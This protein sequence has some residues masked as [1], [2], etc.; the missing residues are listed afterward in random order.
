MRASELRGAA[1]AGAMALAL[2][3]LAPVTA[4]RGVFVD[5]LVMIGAIGG[6]GMLARRVLRSELVAGAVQAAVGVLALCG[7]ALAAR[8]SG[9]ELPRVLAAG[10][11][12]TVTSTAPMGPNPGVRLIAAAAIGVLA[13]L[14]DQL[15]VTYRHA[16]WTL[17][18]LGVPYLLAALALP[19]EASFG[20]LLSLAGGYLLVLLADTAGRV[21]RAAMSTRPGL[22]LL[23]GGLACLLAGASIAVVAGLVTP[24]L[25]PGR[26]APF[27]GQGPIQ[28]GDPSLDLRR[29]L[30]QPADQQ[31]LTYTT[32]TGNGVRL[33]LT[34]LPVFDASGFRLTTRELHTGGVL[35]APPGAPSGLPR[36]QIN[37]SV[38]AFN[39]EWLPL[40]YAP[41]S[42][43]ASG[44]WRHDPLSMSVLATGDR[45]TSATNGL[46]YQATVVDVDP[47]AEQVAAAHAGTPPDA[48]A[49][50]ALPD[51]LPPRI[52]ALAHEI[53]RRGTTDGRRAVLIQDW[54][55]SSA[56]SYSLE[57]APGSGYDALTR[58]LFEDRIGYC[59]QFAT[60]MAV[61]AR[62]VGIPARVAVGFLPGNRDG[63][64]WDVTIHN[65]HA[66]PELYLDGLGWVAFEPTPA[67]AEPPGYAGGNPRAE[68]S[69]SPTP[70]PSATDDEPSL[71]PE[72]P[73]PVPD[74][75]PGQSTNTDWPS[76]PAGAVGLVLLGAA[77]SVLRHR[78]RAHRLAAQPARAAVT[79]AWDEVR[80][81]AWDAGREWPRGSARQIAAT[82]AADLPAEAG[83]ALVRVGMLVERARYADDLGE[84][85]DVATDVR[86][87][88]A[89]LAAGSDG[90]SRWGRALLPRSLWRRLRWRG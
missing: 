46:R 57:P 71:G 23:A 43:T 38:G 28:M 79:G 76:W 78:R 1:V 3:A 10:L 2:P 58:F 26:G 14:A 63:D 73:Q 34:A 61:L 84:V 15:A 30:Q 70:T 4:D 49:T 85:S 81:S 68:P 75:G 39:S 17:L 45:R 50:A 7:L 60:S 48:D 56:F 12:W 62:A 24:G 13:F 90:L 11:E 32:S 65:M 22:R 16:G 8:V 31:V 20:A 82:V 53:T 64:R 37:V 67:I 18:P 77:P 21:P 25:D 27:A 40:P 87:I 55:R 41:A 35:P 83:A 19:G 9:P 54:L 33:R 69:L 44:Q 66:W 89:G 47:T 52:R 51:D 29:N 88:R 6:S 86:R 72:T 42:F 36:Y 5:S 59:E 74:P 80:D